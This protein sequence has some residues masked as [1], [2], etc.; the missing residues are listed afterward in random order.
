[1]HTDRRHSN[2]Y[3]KATRVAKV[4]FICAIMLGQVVPG[5]AQKIASLEVNL[6]TPSNGLTI[7]VKVELDAITF[8]P[9][10]NLVL[11]EVQ[12]TKKIP[13][14]FQIEDQGTRFLYWIVSP[15]KTGK[16]IYELIEDLVMN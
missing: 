10:D 4:F 14:D 16:R 3:S 11:V 8:L 15:E 2:M 6:V 13:V 5:Y 12:G 9:E 1:M 7:P